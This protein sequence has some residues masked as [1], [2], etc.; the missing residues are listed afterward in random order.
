MAHHETLDD[1]AQRLLTDGA[2]LA[3]VRLR[4]ETR[5]VIQGDHGRYVVL[6]PQHGEPT[7]SCPWGRYRANDNHPCSHIRCALLSNAS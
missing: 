6:L 4:T 2:I 7:C 5:F 3:R 1:K